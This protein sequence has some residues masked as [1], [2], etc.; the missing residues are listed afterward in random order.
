MLGRGT[1]C[2][3]I[4]FVVPASAQ[5]VAPHAD[6]LEPYL[7]FEDSSPLSCLVTLLPPFFLQHELELKAFVGSRKFSRLRTAYG[8]RNA[9]DII[10][11]RAM[12]LTD[13]NTAVALFLSTLACF[14]HRMVGLRI[15]VFNLFFP[16]TNESEDEFNRRVANLPS[17]LYL[18]SP[19]ERAGDRDKLQHFFG[20]AL[21]S[22]VFESRG[23][24]DRVG[25]FVEEGEEA[26]IVD[27]VNDERDKSANREGQRFGSALLSDNHLLPSRYLRKSLAPVRVMSEISQCIGVW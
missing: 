4:F 6:S 7:R 21:L 10:F 16:L 13:N 27:G 25:E 9:M 5:V 8:D 20:S 18:D 2:I 15:P 14:D 24:A 12:K 17:H 1:L 23:S 11:V 22:F 3:V 19:P 26:V